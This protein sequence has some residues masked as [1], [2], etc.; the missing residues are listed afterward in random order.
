MDDLT[1]L[2]PPLELVGYVLDDWRM[3]LVARYQ[4]VEE[5]WTAIDRTAGGDLYYRFDKAM[6]DIC[7]RFA[8]SDVSQPSVC[9]PTLPTKADITGHKRSRQSVV[10]ELEGQHTSDISFSPKRRR[11]R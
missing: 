7:A 4:T 5:N 9:L 10:D 3:D 1:S 8:R 6:A 11:V 2:P